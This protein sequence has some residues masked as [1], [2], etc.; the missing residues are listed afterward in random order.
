MKLSN[1]TDISGMFKN[2]V[3]LSEINLRGFIGLTPTNVVELFSGCRSLKNIDL[4][5]VDFA[6]VNKFNNM[7]YNC[8]SLESV[9]LP[10]NAAKES[11]NAYCVSMFKG[12]S[13]LEEINMS[14]FSGK[15][16]HLGASFE[17]CKSLKAVSFGNHKIL[18][19]N[20]TFAG[21]S[22]LKTLDISGFDFSSVDNMGRA[23]EN[24]TSLRRVVLSEGLDVT[25][26]NT[27][28]KMFYNCPRL[29]L[30]CSKWNVKDTTDMT[31]FNEGSPNVAFPG[32]RTSWQTKPL[33]VDTSSYFWMRK[34]S[35][36]N[37]AQTHK[38]PDIFSVTAEKGSSVLTLTDGIGFERLS[39]NNVLWAG[40]I[41][42][43]DG[44]CKP[45]IVTAVD[46]KNNTVTVYPAVEKE[47]SEG[48]FTA[49]LSDSQ[50]LSEMGYK[51]LM[52]YVYSVNPKYSD[53]TVA[54][55]RYAPESV[56]EMSTP[57]KR[58]SGTPAMYNGKRNDYSAWSMS[59]S[60]YGTFLIPYANYLTEGEYGF[61]RE[62]AVDGREGFYETYIGTVYY[63][64]VT[65]VSKIEKDKGHELHIDWYVDGELVSSI[66]KNTNYAERFCFDVPQGAKSVRIRV[67]YTQMRLNKDDT[68]SIGDSTLW[69][70]TGDYGEKLIENNSS[71]VQMFDS[72]GAFWAD[73]KQITENGEVYPQ[74][75]SGKELARL[76]KSDGS[77]L[78][79][80]SI[81]GMTSRY[82]KA[83]F[84]KTVAE[85]H[86]DYVLLDYGINDYHSSTGSDFPNEAAPNGDVIDMSKDMTQDEFSENMYM[87]FSEAISAGITP[88]YVC[89]FI[90]QGPSWVT[91]FVNDTV[92]L[93]E[94]PPFKL[95]AKEGTSIDFEE[96]V[97]FT[98]KL[99]LKNIDGLFICPIGVRTEMNVLDEYGFCG[100]GTQITVNDGNDSSEYILVVKGDVDKDGVCD[101]LDA[102]V[103]QLYANGF[104]E[105]TREEIYAAN[106]CVSEEIDVMSYQ[107]VVNKCLS[108]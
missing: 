62:L 101:V 15:G 9:L 29:Y 7:F 53:K 59:Q 105:P 39:E 8:V 104:Y 46:T 93:C 33:I 60:V 45:C 98:E 73:G 44:S 63:A 10:T 108:S 30:D 11:S 57:Y 25:K 67:Y 77:T 22:S 61:E 65:D 87:I 68:I 6:K 26:V 3:C 31:L 71:V 47:I 36:L 17:D 55:N 38:T 88:I 96:K 84:D 19:F 66:L 50:H 80:R 70:T 43:D 48:L 99:A 81:G 34:E 28:S 35:G 52:Q 106:G 5:A 56:E 102:T 74:G 40:V 79:N 14:G 49:L 94:H 72:W 13:A 42:Y 76:L 69:A 100:T 2:C 92:E 24:C 16:L 21:C 75:A 97:I 103:T 1:I 58:I 51:A 86:P 37:V 4:S 89:G 54:L 20:A 27:M 85:K 82:G 12:C 41:E 64:G 18:G 107:N 90:A 32:I 95:E 83:W 78:V 91:E 23:F